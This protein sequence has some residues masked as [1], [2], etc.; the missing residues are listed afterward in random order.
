MKNKINEDLKNNAFNL[1]NDEIKNL[2]KELRDFDKEYKLSKNKMLEI[3]NGFEVLVD[4]YQKKRT[5]V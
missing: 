5:I 2:E 3:Y 4:N 1:S